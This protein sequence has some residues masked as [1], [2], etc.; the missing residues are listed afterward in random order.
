MSENI[1]DKARRMVAECRVTLVVDAEEGWVGI[2]D[3]PGRRSRKVPGS[4]GQP[5]FVPAR[6]IWR[7]CVH[8]HVYQPHKGDAERRWD[9][10]KHAGETAVLFLV[11]HE[12]RAVLEAFAVQPKHEDQLRL[13]RVLGGMIAS[14]H[15]CGA[16]CVRLEESLNME[17]RDDA[18]TDAVM[19]L[20][21]DP[22]PLF[23]P[24]NGPGVG[25]AWF[26]RARSRRGEYS[27]SRER[28]LAG[29]DLPVSLDV[30]APSRS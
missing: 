1:H 9:R 4:Q 8:T 12:C 24:G 14:Y 21:Q 28:W 22:W 27:R 16:R 10:R 3:R 26:T 11:C 29:G 15:G 13:A 17:D 23:R 20:V 6:P 18:E 5:K 7:D 25:H 19:N 30:D 2:T